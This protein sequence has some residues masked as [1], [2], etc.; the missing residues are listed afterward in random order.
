MGTKSGWLNPLSHPGAPGGNVLSS[1]AGTHGLEVTEWHEFISLKT[2]EVHQWRR[3]G[4]R[5]HAVPLLWGKHGLTGGRVALKNK[6]T[7]L[8]LGR[9]GRTG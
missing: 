8:P 3:E 5:G 4:Y 2:K 1:G 7:R 6:G 9:Q